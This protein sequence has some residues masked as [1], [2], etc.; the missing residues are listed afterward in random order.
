M[1]ESRLEAGGTA[2]EDA[3]APLAT[4]M[5]SLERRLPAG[6]SASVS[7]AL[8]KLMKKFFISSRSGAP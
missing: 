4:G 7:L 5:C 2:G 6:R 3:G 1:M 8:Q